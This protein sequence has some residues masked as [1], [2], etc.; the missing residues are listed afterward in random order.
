M[1]LPGSL[2]HRHSSQFSQAS[3]LSSALR[4]SQTHDRRHRRSTHPEYFGVRIFD[5]DPDWKSLRN[6]HPVKVSFYEWQALDLDIIFLRLYRRR[7]ALDD[8]LKTSIRIRQEINLGS[9]AGTDV[10]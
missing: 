10:L 4:W 5:F 7:N 3:F 9:H 2:K 8:S 1:K 6:P